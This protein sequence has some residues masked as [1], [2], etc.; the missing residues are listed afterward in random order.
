MDARHAVAIVHG[1][2]PANLLADYNKALEAQLRTDIAQALEDAALVIDIPS[3]Y[4]EGIQDGMLR[5]S[6]LVRRRVEY[7]ADNNVVS[8]TETDEETET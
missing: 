5:A 3:A 1:M 7:P 4:R 6:R 2:V 8:V